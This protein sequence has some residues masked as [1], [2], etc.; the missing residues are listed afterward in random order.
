L[1]ALLGTS[2][3]SASRGIATAAKGYSPLATAD[4]GYPNTILMKT[5]NLCYSLVAEYEKTIEMRSPMVMIPMKYSSLMI[6]YA[7]CMAS[8]N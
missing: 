4:K 1:E 2:R 8:C 6:R 3:T 7:P 5:G